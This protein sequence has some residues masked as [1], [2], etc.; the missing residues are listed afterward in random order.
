VRDSIRHG[1]DG[2]VI[3]AAPTDDAAQALAV[4]VGT[5]LADPAAR[6][7]M[8]RRARE[9]ADRFAVGSRVAEVEDLYRRLT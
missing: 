8:G 7:A 5:L 3:P 2:M 9:D 4:A 6:D 1:I